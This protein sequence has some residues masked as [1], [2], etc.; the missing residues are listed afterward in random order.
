MNLRGFGGAQT[1]IG[2][3]T[4]AMARSRD[5]ARTA[6]RLNTLVDG[7]D[8]VVSALEIRARGRVDLMGAGGV[9]V[10]VASLACWS[11]A[12]AGLRRD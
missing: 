1:G 9:A 2:L 4:L 7:L 8:S 5:G 12:A 10:N 3:Y 6:L 11:W